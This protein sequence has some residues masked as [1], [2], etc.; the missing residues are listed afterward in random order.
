LLWLGLPA[1]EETARRLRGV[2]AQFG[3]HATLMRASAEARARLS[4]F[5]PEAPARATL[6]AAVKAAFDP[7][8]LLNPGRMVEEL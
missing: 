2:T 3:G 7:Q 1:D 4:V 6:T 5:E 8:R